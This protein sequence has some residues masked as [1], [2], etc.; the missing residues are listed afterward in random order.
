MNSSLKQ[1]EENEKHIK[2]TLTLK[3]HGSDNEKHISDKNT[4]TTQGQQERTQTFPNIFQV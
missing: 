4:E 3:Q 2:Q 1:R